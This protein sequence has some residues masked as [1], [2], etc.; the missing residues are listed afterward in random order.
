MTS[1]ISYIRSAYPNLAD[2]LIPLV[3][4]AVKVSVRGV[5]ARSIPLG[6]SRYGGL[7]DLPANEP[8]PQGPCGPMTPIAMFRLSEV[9]AAAPW[10]PL[11]SRGLLYLWFDSRWDRWGNELDHARGFTARF[12][13]D[14]ST[15]LVRRPEPARPDLTEQ[16]LN[17]LEPN[18]PDAPLILG[19]H[20]TKLVS[21]WSFGSSLIGF[22]P[23]VD[24]AVEALGEKFSIYKNG[25]VSRPD[26]LLGQPDC[27]Q[28]AFELIPPGPLRD[29]LI[30]EEFAAAG[31]RRPMNAD[32]IAK[33]RDWLLLA[34][35]SEEGKSDW[36]DLGDAGQMLWSIHKDDLARE[37]F[38][39]VWL[40]IQCG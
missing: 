33:S 22:N 15:P 16:Q 36:L 24:A 1:P 34:D 25:W 8:W 31:D 10:S 39:K 18:S 26:Q 9:H 27:F 17:E 21:A 4:P 29:Q 7:P 32:L 13:P 14:E 30:A 12:F 5:T 3:F 38:S 23:A 11:P 2:Q 19:I 35:I 28:S 40:S 20:K 37:D 6:A